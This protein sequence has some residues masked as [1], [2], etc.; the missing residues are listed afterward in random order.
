[1]ESLLSAQLD[2]VSTFSKGTAQSLD[3]LHQA[4]GE[5]IDRLEVGLRNLTLKVGADPGLNDTPML[6]AWE[7]IEYLNS[8]LLEY[9]QSHSRVQQTIATHDQ[10]IAQ[11]KP[12]ITSS[13]S[14]I[15][16]VGILQNQMNQL[17]Q[18]VTVLSQENQVLSMKLRVLQSNSTN[19]SNSSTSM[20]MGSYTS[21]MENVRDSLRR[22]DARLVAVEARMSGSQGLQSSNQLNT[23]QAKFDILEASYVCGRTFLSLPD[24]MS[25]VVTNLPNNVYY[26]FHDAISL[27]E[28]VDPIT[29]HRQDIIIGQFQSSRVGYSTDAES[30]MVTSFKITLP[31]VFCGDK[32]ETSPGTR[33]RHF[34]GCKSYANWNLHD[35]FLV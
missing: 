26:L 31:Q 22:V 6:S 25:W 28:H 13:A 10:W 27:L 1:M 30:R 23:L 4:V 15:Q 20:N 17:L 7:G 11:N 9:G 3:L 21:E 19:S 34:P 12:K 29:V 2:K 18:L 8:L 5:D 24:M 32:K 16:A 33:G 35:G 14:T